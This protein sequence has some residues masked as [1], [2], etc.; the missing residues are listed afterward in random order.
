[1]DHQFPFG[2]KVISDG[3]ACNKMVVI[4][5]LYRAAGA[6]EYQCAYWCNGDHKEVWIADWRLSLAPEFS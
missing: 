5:V 6:A 3:D 2:A 4:G 1:M